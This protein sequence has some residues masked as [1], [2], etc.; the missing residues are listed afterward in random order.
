M[1]DILSN[2]LPQQ[3]IL[4]LWY[5][6]KIFTQSIK[7]LLIKSWMYPIFILIG[8]FFM[9]IF[10]RSW[11]LPLISLGTENKSSLLQWF[12]LFSYGLLFIYVLIFMLLLMVTLYINKP[13][14]LIVMYQK[15]SNQYHQS[16]AVSYYSMIFAHLLMVLF[17]Q[18]LS[19]QHALT[20]LRQLKNWPI[21]Q[22]IA[23]QVS[24]RFDSGIDLKNALDIADLD[25]TFKKFLKIGYYQQNIPLFL[26]KYVQFQKNYLKHSI[27]KGS[28]LLFVI[29]YFQVILI[30]GFLFRIMQIPIEIMSQ[31]L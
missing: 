1:Q 7:A 4:R 9:M 14:R 3:I 30:L 28:R 13:F 2:L 25:F 27:V 6:N 17:N 15:I 20:T 21:I 23:W 16:L 5:E 19:T 10:F 18:G 22:S 31:Y 11:L 24:E 12:T 26:D 8:S 29:A